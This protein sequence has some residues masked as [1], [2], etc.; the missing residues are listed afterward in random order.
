MWATRSDEHFFRAF[1]EDVCRECG[2]KP[3][4]ERADGMEATVRENENGRFLFLSSRLKGRVPVSACR[5]PGR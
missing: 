2:I 1:L 3:L 4:F 5:F